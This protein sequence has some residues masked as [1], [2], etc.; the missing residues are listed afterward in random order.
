MLLAILCATALAANQSVALPDSI[1]RN[2]H[3]VA[4]ESPGTLLIATERGVFRF[5]TSDRKTTPLLSGAALPDGLPDPSSIAS[6]GATLVATSMRAFGGF[7]LRMRDHKRLIAQRTL[8]FV[9]SDV[10]VRGSRACV[11]GATTSGTGDAANAAAFCGAVD[12]AWTNY[13]PLHQLRNGEQGRRVLSTVSWGVTGSIATA[14][15]GS[16][17]VFTAAEPGVFR[18]DKNGAFVE[19]LGK[20]LDDYVIDSRPEVVVRFANDVENRYRLLLNTQPIVDDLVVTPRGPALVVRSVE[21]GK[22]RWDLVW[23]QR[24]GGAAAPLRLGIDRFGPFG[25]VRCAARGTALACVGS[26][27]PR[28]QAASIETAQRWPHLWVFSF[29]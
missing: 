14:D 8:K 5:S 19:I 25:H 17:H 23:P 7:S 22:V 21:K 29:Q 27:P 10:S 11:I 1:G 3:D 20:S 6:D 26:M 24:N 15:D 16:V 12:D 4:W 9:A 13:K 2:A 28:E 18:Y